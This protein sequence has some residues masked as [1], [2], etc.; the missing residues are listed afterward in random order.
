MK[1]AVVGRGNVGGRL[2][3]LWEQANHEVKRIGV[4]AATSLTP[5]PWS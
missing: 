1:I 2:G 3:D 5:R 4:R